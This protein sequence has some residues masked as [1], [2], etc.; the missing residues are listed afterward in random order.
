MEK[1]RPSFN[2]IIWNPN[3]RK[4]E[5]YDIMPRLLNN[6]PKEKFKTREDLCIWL[7]TELR[8][9]FWGRCEYEVI[10][11]DWPCQKDSEKIDIYWQAAM[12]IRNITNILWDYLN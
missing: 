1:S 3:A 10:L 4:F 9:H 11:T 12:N 5:P 7:S 8:Y 6:L 2:C